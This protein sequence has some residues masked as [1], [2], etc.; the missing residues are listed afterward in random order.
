MTTLRTTIDLPAPLLRE[1]KSRAAQA[2]V[3]MKFLLSQWVEAALRGS[4]LPSP[5]CAQP[6]TSPH[7]LPSFVRSRDAQAP[8]QAA[9]SN[10]QLNALLHEADVQRVSGKA[11]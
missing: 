7:P 3:S 2:G 1:V 4:Q 8:V 10:A 11:P 9:L 5:A 6:M